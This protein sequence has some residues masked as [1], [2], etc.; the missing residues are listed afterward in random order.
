[1]SAATHLWTD[2]WRRTEWFEC[3]ECGAR[4]EVSDFVWA[5]VPVMGEKPTL[6]VCEHRPHIPPAPA[7]L[8]AFECGRAIVDLYVRLHELE[9][10]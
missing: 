1:M 9:K 8:A 3:P 6:D 10:P 7:T 4:Q 2:H 5:R